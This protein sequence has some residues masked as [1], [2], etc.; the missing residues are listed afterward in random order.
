MVMRRFLIPAF[1][2]SLLGLVAGSTGCAD[3]DDDVA[4]S[5]DELRALT[6]RDADNGK[7]F[8]VEKGQSFKV[9]LQANATTGYAWQVASTSK[10]L[11]WPSPREGVY[12][13]GGAGGP[14]GSGGVQVFTWKT[15]SPLL[16]P[17]T[18][19]HAI[20]L[21]YRRPWESEDTPA[22]QTFKF[23]IKVKAGTTQPEP[24]PAIPIVLFEGHNGSQIQAT[25]GQPL[26][27]LLPENPTTGYRWH[28]E[29]DGALA[30]PKKTFEDPDSAGPVGGGG[31]V[32][33]VW[34]TENKVGTHTISLKESRGATGAAVATFELT[35]NVVAADADPGFECPPARLGTV[36]CQPPTNGKK[37]CKRDY[38]TWAEANCDV[39]YLD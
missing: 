13:G 2:L 21:E 22:A 6:I 38:R 26:V 5:Q 3:V 20:T 12:E 39:S 32:S 17:S 15:D 16:K 23:K 36:N 30:A 33:F 18:T 24:E 1:A 37:Y 11:G 14:I 27:V 7:T 31:T 35:L 10:K 9:E 19:A 8:T 28:V 4:A 25:E 29:D 34:K